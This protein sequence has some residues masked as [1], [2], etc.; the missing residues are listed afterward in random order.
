MIN[1][2]YVSDDLRVDG[3]VLMIDGIGPIAQYHCYCEML[4]SHNIIYYAR[5]YFEQEVARRLKSG[6]DTD[7]HRTHLASLNS[8]IMEYEKQQK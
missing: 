1:L 7:V 4:Y 5:D 3:E 8:K 2:E 6:E